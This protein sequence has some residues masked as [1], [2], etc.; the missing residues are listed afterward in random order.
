MT[1]AA[2]GTVLLAE[3]GLHRSR[4]PQRRKLLKDAD[5]AVRSA[6]AWLS[7]HWSVRL[8][9]DT[10]DDRVTYTLYGLER[11]CV[12]EGVRRLG[13][14]DWYR[15]GALWLLQVQRED[16]SFPGH[17]HDTCFALLFLKRASFRTANAVITPSEKA[18]DP[19]GRSPATCTTSA[20][21]CSSSSARP[22]PA[23]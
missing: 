2:I 1:A 5:G 17:L 16:G 23:S 18:P 19:T 15:E 14:R 21:R 7:A 8:P 12:L 4:S 6:L 9:W 3:E 20:S 11:A 22:R 10:E 13:G